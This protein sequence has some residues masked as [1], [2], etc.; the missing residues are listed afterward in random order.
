MEIKKENELILSK[1]AEDYFDKCN[2]LK[3]SLIGDK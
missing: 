3:I 2:D 1:Q